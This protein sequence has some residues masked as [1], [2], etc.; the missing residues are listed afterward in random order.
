[1]HVDS[2]KVAGGCI[3][4]KV[5]AV[6]SV[7]LTVPDMRSGPVDALLVEGIATY[8]NN[9]N[10]TGNSFWN[11]VASEIPGHLPEQ[12]RERYRTADFLAK[13]TF[14]FLR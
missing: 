6:V 5:R 3:S 13:L 10:P 4:S 14:M 8:N 7:A 9:Y 12:C 1:V 11:Q 2:Y